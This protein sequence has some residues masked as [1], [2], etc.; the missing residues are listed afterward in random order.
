MTLITPSTASIFQTG[1]QGLQKAES[2][3]ADAARKIAEGEVEAEH[4][5]N[6]ITAEAAHKANAAVIRV[7][8]RMQDQLLDILA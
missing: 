1:V 7:A 6:L 5:V 8:D 4:I 3:A 2:Q